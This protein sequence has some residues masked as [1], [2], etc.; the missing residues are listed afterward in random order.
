[1]GVGE[2]IQGRVCL[3]RDL[4][5]ET[6]GGTRHSGAGIFQAGDT[7]RAKAPRRV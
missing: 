3:N 2:E 1:M 6:G 7:A 4:H 5:G